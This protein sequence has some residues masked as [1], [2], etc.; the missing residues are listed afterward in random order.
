M[1]P[2]VIPFKSLG[3]QVGLRGRRRADRR[4]EELAAQWAGR[5]DH[6]HGNRRETGGVA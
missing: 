4:W 3:G 6:R 2:Q 1:N 5:H